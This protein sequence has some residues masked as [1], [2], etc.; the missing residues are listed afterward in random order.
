MQVSNRTLLAKKQ[1][2]KKIMYSEEQFKGFANE[3]LQIIGGINW[4][5]TGSLSDG[6]SDEHPLKPVL[7]A[8]AIIKLDLDTLL[9]EKESSQEYL[10]ESEE[11]YRNIL[12]SIEDG[13]FEVDL[14][15]NFTFFNP[16]MSTILGCSKEE[17]SGMNNRAF[18]DPEN[19]KK[20]FRAFNEVYATGIP[21]KG[22]EWEIIQKKGSRR[23]IR[24]LEVSVSLIVSPGEKPTGFRGIARD[25]TERK[26]I[27]I[28]KQAKLKAEAASKAKSQFLA[29]MSH[30]IRTP[31]NGIMGMAE[32]CLETALDEEQKHLV[33]TITKEAHSLLGIINAVLDFS[34]IEAGKLEL[35]HIPFDL[36]NV[37]E[38]VTEAFSQQAIQKGLE[39]ISFITP[40]TPTRIVGDPGRLKQVLRNLIGNAIKFTHE[41]RIVIKAAP[42]Q[43]LGDRIKLRF[44]VKDTGIG[45]PKGKQAF[46]FESFTQADGSTTRK[47]GGTGL[48]ITI[49]KQLAELMG[50][51]MGVDSV[52]GKGSAFW[53]SAVFSIQRQTD[54][55]VRKKMPLSNARVLLVD[56]NK[57]SRQT[58]VEYIRS[59]GSLPVQAASAKEALAILKGS[60]NDGE[61]F[62]LVL[63]ELNMP[64][65][66]GFDLAR[67]IRSIEFLNSI[68]IIIISSYGNPGDGKTCR[69][70]G[71]AGYLTKPITEIGLCLAIESVLGTSLSSET[72]GEINLVT[73][74][75]GAEGK[76]K[77]F[78][79]LLADDYPTN[80][81]IAKRHLERA[82]YQV[83]LAENGKLALE[84]FKRKHYDLILMDIQM[85]IMDGYQATKA[86]RK[87]ESE[88]AAME[89][90]NTLE[91]M[92]RVPIVAITAH[93]MREY[94][95]LCLES[96]MDDFLAKPLTRKELLAMATKWLKSSSI[97]SSSSEASF[98]SPSLETGKDVPLIIAGKPGKPIDME[99]AIDEF[100]GDKELLSEVIVGF[101]EKVIEQIETIRA[102][103]SCGDAETVRIEAHSIKGG[104]ASLTAE[105]LS[106]VASDLE[107]KGKSKELNGAYE[108]LDNLEREFDVLRRYIKENF[109]RGMT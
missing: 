34:K 107:S 59:W 51:E 109:P 1:K 38:D 40:D 85:P 20:V 36:R 3:M 24:Y 63:S 26:M 95:E 93:A 97:Q 60:I 35:E 72:G 70:I 43:E 46:V 53:F 91:T 7:D 78:H 80:Q 10:K 41:G 65:M 86:I 83:D 21:K 37:F 11:K 108:I 69:D 29:N 75:T 66:N 92:Q 82:G 19:S 50:G 67:E 5:Q 96:G 13:Y 15:G 32:V 103:L 30:E 73:K 16:A 90:E 58:I 28:T 89:S 61:K 44:M 48:G 52:E 81:E 18:M 14:N 105:N 47:Y 74:Y 49:S 87:I 57:T 31:L 8:L 79:V 104:A 17:M 33:C 84:A 101:T 22:F 12:E 71:I 25:I 2:T 99:K 64:E 77:E 39:L 68:M 6:M 27:E 56:D 54:L 102:A 9:Q 42:A 23:N 4:D 55:Q 106:K 45:I 100:E 88:L 94:K 98:S 76:R 62:D